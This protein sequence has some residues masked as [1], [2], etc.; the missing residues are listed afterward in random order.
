MEVWNG[1][2][3]LTSTGPM[4]PL[5]LLISLLPFL[6]GEAVVPPPIRTREVNLGDILEVFLSRGIVPNMSFRFTAAG[7]RKIR[8][9]LRATSGTITFEAI[10]WRACVVPLPAAIPSKI[11]GLIGRMMI[12]RV[13]LINNFC[14]GFCWKCH[15][16]RLSFI[17][18]TSVSSYQW[19]SFGVALC[20]IFV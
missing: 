3:L 12:G 1:W 16:Q 14:G 9:L 10:V 17:F 19:I 5:G 15:Y 2:A 13:R 8:V 6:V 18:V 20:V 11:S 4:G 7:S